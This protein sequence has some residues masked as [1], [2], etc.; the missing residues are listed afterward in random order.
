MSKILVVDDDTDSCEAV[1]RFLTKSGHSVRCTHNGRDAMAALGASMPDLILVDV[2][3]PVMDGIALI[4]VI[5]SY[6]RWSN[7]PIAVITAYPEDPR[8]HHLNELGVR[9]V[10][11]KSEFTFDDLAEWTRIAGGPAPVASSPPRPFMQH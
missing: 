3:M 9:R 1:A 5:R 10:F 4:E 7:I 2:R 8:L 6:L 11:R